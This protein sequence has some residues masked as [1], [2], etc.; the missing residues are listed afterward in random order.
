M[1][2]KKGDQIIVIQGKDKGRKGKIEKVF[3]QKGKV[4]IPGINLYKKHARKQSEKKQGGIIEIV[5]PLSISNVALF[6]SKCRRPTRIG[7]Q[8]DKSG[9]KSRICRRCQNLI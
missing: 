2:L 4:L 3:P 1:K 6:C 7:Y 9:N 8:I 5:K